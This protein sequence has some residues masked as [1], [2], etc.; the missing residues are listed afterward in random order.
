MKKKINKLFLIILILIMA[1]SLFIIV[2]SVLS[3]QGASA[4]FESFGSFATG[5]KRGFSIESKENNVYNIGNYEVNLN[6]DKLLIIDLSIQS[7]KDSYKN[8]LE[9]NI[10]IQNAVLDAFSNYETTYSAITPQGKKHIKKHIKDNINK[11][12]SDAPI[13]EVYFNKFIIQ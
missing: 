13:K 11:T 8:I 5:K 10:V 4:S 12:L 9:H 6:S 2:S 3:K 7:E 1:F